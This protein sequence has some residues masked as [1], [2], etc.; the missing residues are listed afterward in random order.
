VGFSLVTVLYKITTSEEWARAETAGRFAGS[1]L[2]LRDGFIHLSTAEQVQ[3]TARLH[4]AGQEN[5]VLV[6][7]TEDSVA[8]HLKWEIS[9]GGQ[10]FPHVYS[11][12]NVTNIEWIKPLPWVGNTHEF[13][14]EFNR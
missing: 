6:A 1:A 7:L 8:E 4:F 13:P 10:M 9:R 5:L 2:D 3:D 14:A 11:S 12:L